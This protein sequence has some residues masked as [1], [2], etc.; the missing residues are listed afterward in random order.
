[1]SKKIIA[2][3]L[4]SVSLLTPGI[5]FASLPSDEEHLMTPTVLEK[6]TKES[7]NENNPSA[8]NFSEEENPAELLA[9]EPS[10]EKIN[11]SQPKEDE[12]LVEIL[13]DESSKHVRDVCPFLCNLI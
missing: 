7:S 5:A 6:I 8:K 12:V 13:S 3:V 11:D 1:M 4:L 2:P 10:E 9:E